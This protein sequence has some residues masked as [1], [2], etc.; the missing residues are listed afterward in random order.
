ML[1]LEKEPTACVAEFLS[2]DF[3][4][5]AAGICVVPFVLV[6]NG[7]THGETSASLAFVH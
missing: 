4:R 1:A 3:S 2:P 7:A 5:G 6:Q